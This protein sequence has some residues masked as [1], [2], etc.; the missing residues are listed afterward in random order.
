MGRSDN[1]K[2][3][4]SLRYL[5]PIFSQISRI[6]LFRYCYCQV[7]SIAKATIIHNIDKRHKLSSA[8]L[9]ICCPAVLTFDSSSIFR[10]PN[11]PE[12]HTA[13]SVQSSCSVE[14]L[15]SPAAGERRCS[16]HQQPAA[17]AAE[18]GRRA[19]AG[20]HHTDPPAEVLQYGGH[21]VKSFLSPFLH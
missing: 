6:Y 13:V 8:I 21:S 14:Q 5:H 3:D 11:F 4:N 7:T 12:G 18:H 10:F 17:G 15:C 19:V 9:Q 2:Y 1:I 16:R 20:A